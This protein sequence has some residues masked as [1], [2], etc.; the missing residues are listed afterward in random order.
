MFAMSAGLAREPFWSMTCRAAISTGLVDGGIAISA[1][2]NF[3]P[4]ARKS[5]RYRLKVELLPERCSSITSH[6][7]ASKTTPP[8]ASLRAVRLMILKSRSLI[9]M[10]K[11]RATP[12]VAG[13]L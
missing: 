11:T 5:A 13:I 7:N 9:D 12:F 4:R 2:V 1:T 8:I 3:S 10:S 6:A